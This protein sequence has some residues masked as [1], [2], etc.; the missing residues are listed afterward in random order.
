MPARRFVV[1]QLLP[2]LFCLVPVAGVVLL[3]LAIPDQAMRFYL[4]SIG[5]SYL[6]WIILALG[7]SIFLW[8][9][10]LA[11]RGM[12]WRERTFDERGDP[13]LQRLY[14]TAEWF[15]LLGLFGTV[16][17]IIQTFGAIG[18]QDNVPQRDIIRLYAPA[19]TA[20]A[21]GLLMTLVN[22]VPLWLTAVGRMLILTLAVPPSSHHLPHGSASRLSGKESSP[23]A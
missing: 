1:R 3:I 2:A 20:T 4:D 16:I 11:W 6:D 22:I 14:Q 21:S 18:G 8:Q 12:R 15:P 9:M 23:H 19:L 13:L 10:A 17:G 7:T 5:S